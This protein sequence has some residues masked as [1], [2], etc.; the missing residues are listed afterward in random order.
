MGADI[1]V[2]VEVKL[3]DKW[4][5]FSEKYFSTYYQSDIDKLISPFDWRS[6]SMFS[7]LAGV[8]N[9]CDVIPIKEPTYSLPED[10]SEYIKSEWEENWKGD[11]HSISFL[12]I[13]E[14]IEFDYNKNIDSDT[15]SRRIL[16]EKIPN[17]NTTYNGN[18]DDFFS[19]Y[20][21]L[22]GG[23]DSMF[24][25]HLK[26]LCKLGSLDDVRIIFWFDN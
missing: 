1:H 9:S 14:L 26:E 24:F 10:I 22:L 13:R 25:T 5:Y 12:T 15:N 3:N 4:E 6:Y 7:F 19:D 8:R 20:Y 18:N 11:G 23:P 16:V 21:D 17:N 2:Y